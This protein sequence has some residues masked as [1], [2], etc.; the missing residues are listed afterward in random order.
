MACF[1]V[2]TPDSGWGFFL[3][4]AELTILSIT[5]PSPRRC[6]RSRTGCAQ[7][8]SWRPRLHVISS[9]VTPRR[10]ISTI[11]REHGIGSIDIQKGSVVVV[12]VMDLN[13]VGPSDGWFSVIGR[14]MTSATIT[15]TQPECR[16][17]ARRRFTGD[18]RIAYG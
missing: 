10:A 16:R 5:R 13:V 9:W 8:S 2:P 4:P 3:L 14:G 1:S 12:S 11:E 15:S 6:Q 7:S 18:G 17:I